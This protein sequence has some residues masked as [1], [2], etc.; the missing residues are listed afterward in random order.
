MRIAI[1]SRV[2]ALSRI[3]APAPARPGTSPP[4]LAGSR[5]SNQTWPDMPDM[6]ARTAPEA[7]P[8]GPPGTVRIVPWQGSG[9]VES[10]LQSAPEMAV[11]GPLP[12]APT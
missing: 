7:L 1:A 6:A 3:D 11:S 10:A 9:T 2:P 8:D 5:T 12:P 4:P